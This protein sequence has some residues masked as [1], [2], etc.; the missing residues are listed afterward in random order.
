MPVSNSSK[1]IMHASTSEE[2]LERLSWGFFSNAKRLRPVHSLCLWIDISG[3][4]AALSNCNWDLELAQEKGLMGI[5]SDVYSIAALP[6]LVQYPPKSSERTLVLNDGIAR[7]IDVI[8]PGDVEK[9]Q[10]LFY[11]RDTLVAHYILVPKLRE[12]ELS[13]RS[14]FAGGQRVQYAPVRVTGKS[15]LNYDK[16]RMTKD[17]R[18][19]LNQ[20]LVNHPVQF[21]MNTAFSRAYLIEKAGRQKGI[22]P[23][24]IYV[25]DTFIEVLKRAMPGCVSLIRKGGEG[26]IEFGWDGKTMLHLSYDKEIPIELEYLKSDV[27]QLSD[28]VVYESLEGETTEFPLRPDEMN[29][30]PPRPIIV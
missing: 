26:R 4:A 11:I 9:E 30:K 13:I 23:N 15:F 25:E 16:D 18:K 5:L 24:R 1:S 10:W 12:K 17:T 27:F 20:E 14:V 22:N 3:F 2:T 7:T 8:G 6:R 28:L 29:W 19:F 21:Q